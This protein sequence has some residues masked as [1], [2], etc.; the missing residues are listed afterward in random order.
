MAISTFRARRLAAAR[1]A[2]HARSIPVLRSRL[3]EGF[4]ADLQGL[5]DA[6][7]RTD[8]N[9]HYRVTGGMLLGWAREKDILSHDTLDA[10][11]A[12]LDED[13]HRLVS[14]VPEITK[15][16]F[17]CDRRF[18]NNDGDVTELTFMRHGA[19]FDFFRNFPAGGRLRYFLYGGTRNRPTE[20]RASVPAQKMVPFSFLDRTWLKHQDHDLELRSIYG[21]WQIPDPSWSY[22]DAG[23]IEVRRTWYRSDFDWVGDAATLSSGPAGP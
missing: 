14:A 15:A 10:D 19:S 3:R 6:I 4:I 9:G 5:H 8:L 22:L 16:G 13:F 17:K 2:L 1:L 12:V 7:E 18:V 20:A 23:N 21:T 11:F